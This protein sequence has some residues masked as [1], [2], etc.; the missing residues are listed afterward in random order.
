MKA[1]T[2]DVGKVTVID[3]DGKITIG[4][5]DLVL[6]EA[7]DGVLKGGKSRI[8]LNLNGVSYMD[9]AGIGELVACYKRVAE[10]KGIMKLV[11]PGGRVQDL[12]AL[13][14]L[15]EYFETF[16]T[17]AEALASFAA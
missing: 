3:L 7:V 11:N 2:R 12:L 1:S 15:D 13:T 14:K 9:S 10:K 8:L 5:G 4:K 6:R 16:T 17:E